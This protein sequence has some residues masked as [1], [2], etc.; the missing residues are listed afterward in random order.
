LPLQALLFGKARH[1]EERVAEDHP[2]RPLRL[3]AEIVAVEVDLLAEFLDAVEVVEE[4]QLRLRLAFLGGVSQILDQRLRMDLLLDVDRD[5]RDLERLAVLLVLSLPNEL[6]VERRV[7]R[8]EE[9]LRRLLLR[10][11]ELAQLFGRDVDA[12]VLVLDGLDR[13]RALRTPA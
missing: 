5:D 7:P 1:D 6:R 10:A 13:P 4:R 11:N 8:V 12:L 9:S 2:V 3:A